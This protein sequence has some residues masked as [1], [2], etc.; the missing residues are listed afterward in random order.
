ML[1]KQKVADRGSRKLVQLIALDSSGHPVFPIVLGGLTVYSQGDMITG[2]ML[3]HDQCAIYPVG[4][5]STRFFASMKS[6]DQQCLYTCQIKDRGGESIAASSALTCHSNLLKNRWI[7]FIVLFFSHYLTFMA[8]I[9][10]SGADFFCFSHST[11]QNLIQYFPGA[12]KH[13][14]CVVHGQAL[15]SLLEDNA[16]VNFEPY[17]RHQ[18]FDDSMRVEHNLVGEAEQFGTDFLYLAVP[19]RLFLYLQ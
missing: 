9:M 17:Q 18:G 1:K 10:P 3:F 8:H 16:S 19:S 11:V 5:C 7:H 14:K 4:Y 15:H 6:P 12:H 2:S 13:C